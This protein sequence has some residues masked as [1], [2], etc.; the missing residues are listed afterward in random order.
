[1]TCK[2]CGVPLNK[3]GNCTFCGIASKIEEL[4]GKEYMFTSYTE[5]T[6]YKNKKPR[7]KLG[8]RKRVFK[9]DKNAKKEL[10]RDI[11]R[12]SLYKK[13]MEGYY[14]FD[15]ID[16]IPRVMF[17]MFVDFYENG[18][19]DIVNWDSDKGHIK[20]K[21]KMDK[22]YT[23]IKYRLPEFQKQADEA[24]HMWAGH[25]EIIEKPSDTPNCVEINFQTEEGHKHFN[26]LYTKLI[27]KITKLTNK[28]CKKIINIREF[29]WT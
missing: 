23:F 27:L 1:M 18:Q 21:R 19:L 14:S 15:L 5:K 20:A 26:D 28:Y 13:M 24:I 12:K 10:Q 9:Y 17:A 11:K 4:T 3:E 2:N 7:K 22:I 16:T 29:L 25:T 6:T 8:M